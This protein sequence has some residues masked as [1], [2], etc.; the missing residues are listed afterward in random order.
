MSYSHRGS[1]PHGRTRSPPASVCGVRRASNPAPAP[2]PAPLSTPSRPDASSSLLFSLLQS[3]LPHSEP[4]RTLY[5]R[6][7]LPC[8]AARRA[9]SAL[10]PAPVRVRHPT[11]AL[12]HPTPRTRERTPRLS[13]LPKVLLS[14]FPRR[15]TST[16]F[17]PVPALYS[18]HGRSAGCV[19]SG[20]ATPPAALGSAR[21]SMEGEARA[22]DGLN[23][24]VGAC[25]EDAW[26]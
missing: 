18:K 23:Y 22:R 7:T 8:A 26:K 6:P 17:R 25:T 12:R 10:P 11:H 4:R 14:L 3:R 19:P 24:V 15:A 21:D 20:L 5:A 2:A 1:A 16:Y 9:R 13:R